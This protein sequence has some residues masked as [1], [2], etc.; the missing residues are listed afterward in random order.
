MKYLLSLIVALLLISFSS[1]RDDFNFEPSDGKLEFSKDTVYFDTV[2]SNIGSSTYQL[3]VYNRSDKDISIPSIKFKEGDA[4]KYRMMVDGMSGKSFQNVELLAKD[5]MFIFIET[6]IDYNEYSSPTADFLYTDQL[7][8]DNGA[9]Q[10]EVEL[11][12]LVKDAYFLYPQRYADG[13]Y[14]HILLGDDAIYGF[15]LDEQDPVNGNELVWNANKPYVIYGYA[16]IPNNKTLTIQAG[17]EVH[18]HD[19][20]G[21]LTPFGSRIE[22]AGTL[23]HP[24]VIQGDR[25]EPAF[26]DVSGQWGT[27]WMTQGSSGSFKNVTIKNGTIG[28]LIE[29]NEDTIT[30]DNVQLYNHTQY[31]ILARTATLEGHNMVINNCGAA[32][33]AGSLGGNYRFDHCTFANYWS[34]GSKVPV[35]LDNGDGTAVYALERAL[36]TN[37]ILYGTGQYSL[38]LVKE[39]TGNFNYQFENSFIKFSDSGQYNNNN[40]YPIANTANYTNCVIT[41]SSSKSP[42]FRAPRANDL[43]INEKSAALGL[44]GNSSWTP[45]DILGE[46]RPT[47]GADAGAY[48]HVIFE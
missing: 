27:I 3:K 4:S 26:E 2:F 12:T 41:K 45:L 46:N 17:A 1:C 42:Q 10:Q 39:G 21:I 28:L 18:F 5:S 7:L 14:E 35:Y 36:F 47:T 30:F 43:R 33:F 9:N 48:N 29:K 38:N 44:G 8:F 40:L 15:L 22:A 20:S 11:V 34:Q 19:A 6:T 24:I 25:L 13:S 31:G 16:T 37:C 23:E 32:G